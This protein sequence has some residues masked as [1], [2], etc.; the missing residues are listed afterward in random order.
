LKEIPRSTTAVPFCFDIAATVCPAQSPT[1][2]ASVS[3]ALDETSNSEPKAALTCVCDAR[4]FA[5]QTGMDA[6][7]AFI[8]IRHKQI[9]IRD[10]EGLARM[11]T[12]PH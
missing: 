7:T 6:S 8:N 11:R 2:V 10:L 3:R 9:R 4:A 1:A 12:L 5:G